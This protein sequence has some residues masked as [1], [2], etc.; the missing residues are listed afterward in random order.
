MGMWFGTEVIT[1]HDH[2][3]G[4]YRYD[5]CIIVHLSE[6]THEVIAIFVVVLSVLR[7]SEIFRKQ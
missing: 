3:V 7:R 4:E 1:H 2:D 6:V 5:S